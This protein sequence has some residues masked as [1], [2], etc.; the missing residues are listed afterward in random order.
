[1]TNIEDLKAEKITIFDCM[2]T[3]EKIIQTVNELPE[4]FSVEELFE[5][6]VLLQKIE[7][8]IEQSKKGDVVSTE[9]AKKRLSKW[10][11]K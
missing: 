2:L 5:R 8:G 10:V 3:K 4:N 1:M 9:E 6:V 7:R 11:S